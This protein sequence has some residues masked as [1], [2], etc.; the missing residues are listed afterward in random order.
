MLSCSFLVDLIGGKQDKEQCALNQKERQLYP[1]CEGK[2]AVSSLF[3]YLIQS[4]LWEISVSLCMLSYNMVGCKM[5]FTTMKQLNVFYYS[6]FFWNFI[7]ILLLHKSG[8][9]LV[10]HLSRPILVLLS[11]P[12]LCYSLLAFKI[13]WQKWIPQ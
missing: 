11:S 5:I 9:M 2:I 3:F 13:I 8:I 6:Q 1:K 4:S 7:L 10:V 12:Y